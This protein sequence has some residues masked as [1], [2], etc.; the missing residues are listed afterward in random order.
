MNDWSM[1]KK[2]IWLHIVK[3][4][5]GI[6]RTV[7]G[8]IVHVINALARPAISVKCEVNPIQ[9]LHGYD[10]PWP[11]GG[12]KNLLKVTATTQTKDG[13]T[14]TVNSDGTVSCSGTANADGWFALNNGVSFMANVGYILNGCPSG[15]GSSTYKLNFAESVAVDI[16]NG[17]AVY[18][19]TEDKTW[20]ARLQYKS[21]TNMSGLTFKPMLRLSTVSDATFAPYSNICPISGRTS[22]TVTRTG[23]NLVETVPVNR[24]NAGITFTTNADGSVH[25]VGTSTGT[26]WWKPATTIADW[27]FLKA[28]TYTLSGGKSSAKMLY[29]IG[30]M[31]DGT[32]INNTSVGSVYDRGS[33]CTFTMP[34]DGWLNYQIQISGGQTIDEVYY[35][36]IRLASETDSTFEPYQGNTYTITL[37]DT[38][39]GGQLDVTGGKMVVDRAYLQKR[40]GDMDNTDTAPGWKSSGVKDIIGA[41][42]NAQ[43]V[44]AI[45]SAFSSQFIRANTNGVNDIL[46]FHASGIGKTQTE[47]IAAMPDLTVDFV[48]PLAQ[49]FEITLTPTQIDM[50]LGENNLWADAGDLTLT[51]YADG[52]ASTSEALGI[53]LGGTYNN[54]GGADDVSDDEALEILLGGS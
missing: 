26:A 53:L 51:Y 19:P 13:I 50:L 1:L 49:P 54:P 16:G 28:G 14:F 31:V 44:G 30:Q 43:I 24:T 5:G 15:G 38:V 46:F 8:A 20:I 33:G 35:P 17:S 11:A 12:G 22:A 9:Y 37:G 48:I 39:Y 47:L 21:G 2:L 42:F 36:M 10:S 41:G 40:I 4:G 7:K 6:E 34:K 3:G 18:T 27:K 23:K 29:I 32:A 45:C 25:A 52:N